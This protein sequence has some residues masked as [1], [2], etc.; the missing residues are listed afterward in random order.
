MELDWTT[1]VLE[2][3]N[4][5]VLIWI[6]NRLLYRPLMN[7]I[8]QRKAAIQKTLSDAEAVRGQAQALQTHYENRLADWDQER[9]KAR[10]QLREEIAAE[11][12][13]LLD[14]V[15]GELDQERKKAAAVDQR[16]MKEFK[17][18]AEATAI[19][20][21]TTFA[22]R[23]LSRLSGPELER[24]IIDMVIDDLRRLPDEQKQAIRSA[25]SAAEL[26]MRITSAY[27]LDQS[28]RGA[29]CQACRT[30]AGREV[31][32]DFLEDRTL[33][34]GVRVSFGAWVLRANLQ[35]ELS[36]FVGSLH[37]A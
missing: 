21:G 13:R 5:L 17:Q 28:Q 36:F 22:S 4:F 7:V 6:L 15:R 8:A 34:S 12:V 33:I 29:L 20:H 27:P 23:L 32:C 16:R 31:T 26:S 30:L 3:I 11:R 35:D 18:Q 25:P 19:E 1:F 37:H 24:R 14:N 2:L 9:E 10:E